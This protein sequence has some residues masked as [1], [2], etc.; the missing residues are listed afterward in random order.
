MKVVYFLGAALFGFIG[1]LLLSLIFSPAIMIVSFPL[2][3]FLSFNVLTI[4]IRVKEKGIAALER[5]LSDL[6]ENNMG[7]V[8]SAYRKTVSTNSF[9]KKS[10]DKFKRQLLEYL[11]DN[12]KSDDVIRYNDEFG[13]FLIPDETMQSIESVIEEHLSVLDYDDDMDPYEYEHFCAKQF[14]LSGWDEAYATSGSADQGADVIAKRGKEQLVG[15][16]K[17]Y[18]KPVGNKAV[19]EVLGAKKFYNANSAV[20][21]SNAGFTKSA[22]ALAKTGNVK[23]I[24]HSEIKDL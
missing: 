15:Q 7:L 12:T 18:G 3:T 22:E 2:I 14:E 20:V 8:S 11:I 5:E 6:I 24:H 10:Y 17:K 19:Q 16:C 4:K 23:L 21:I 1:S 9:G 13:D